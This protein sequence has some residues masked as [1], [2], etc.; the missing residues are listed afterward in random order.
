VTLLDPILT[1]IDAELHFTARV[2]NT[3]REPVYVYTIPNT[4]ASGSRPGTAYA[5]LTD[6]D[7]ELRLTLLPSPLPPDVSVPYRVQPFATRLEPRT[8]LP[9]DIRLPVPVVEWYGYST[10]D[11]T[12]DEWEAVSAYMVTVS[13]GYVREPEALFV[14]EVDEPNGVWDVGGE[15]IRELAARLVPDQRVPVRKMPI[16][17]AR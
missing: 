15:M 10:S 8:E 4:A 14:Q 2:R 7:T 9:I 12:G 6:D 1:V 11:Y 3:G 16:R 13:I 5:L 17:P